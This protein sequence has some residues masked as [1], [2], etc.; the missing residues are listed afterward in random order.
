MAIELTERDHD[1]LDRFIAKALDGYR[2]G[3]ITS[4]EARF[5]L[6]HVIAAAADDNF[7]QVVTFMEMKLK[8]WENA[9]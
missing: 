8:A 6:A 2:S 5:T 1:L 9:A 4:A 3:E 7:D